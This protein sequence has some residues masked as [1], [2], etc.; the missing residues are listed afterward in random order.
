MRRSSDSRIREARARRALHPDRAGRR[1]SGSATYAHTPV[2]LLFV[3]SQARLRS[4]TAADVFAAY[5]G[6][7]TM[8][9]GTDRDA[10]TPLSG[11]LIEWADVILA[12]ERSHKAKIARRFQHLLRH[13]KL[14]VLGVPDDF[15]YMDPELV[16]LLEVRVRRHVRV[17]AT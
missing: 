13:K 12:M 15:G 4:P 6:I 1:R 9:A 11:D 8:Y 14:S 3:C 10:E 2:N 5:D 17:Q 16:S 7:D